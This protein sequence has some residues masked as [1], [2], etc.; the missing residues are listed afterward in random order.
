MLQEF[1]RGKG[2]PVD[3]DSVGDVV[4]GRAVKLEV[5]QAAWL[6]TW[7]QRIGG[8]L[9]QRCQAVADDCRIVCRLHSNDGRFQFHSL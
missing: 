4:N 8:I 5:Y 1:S 6:R 3:V 7:P 9:V 2:L